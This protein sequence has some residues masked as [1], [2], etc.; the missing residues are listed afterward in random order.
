[1]HSI[2]SFG[3]LCAFD[4]VCCIFSYVALSFIW[5]YHIFCCLWRIVIL[6]LL[7]FPQLCYS[8]FIGFVPVLFLFYVLWQSHTPAQ[9]WLTLFPSLPSYSLSFRI[10]KLSFQSFTLLFLINYLFTFQMLPPFLAP[11]HKFVIPWGCDPL[12]LLQS[13]SELFL[14]GPSVVEL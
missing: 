5:L 9:A 8:I 4:L 11:P 13:F 1:M 3:F 2:S 6:C 12:Q 14:K 10:A 7:T